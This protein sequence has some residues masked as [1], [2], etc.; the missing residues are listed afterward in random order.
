M[1]KK[2]QQM[3]V[4]MG[5]LCLILVCSSLA[6]AADEPSP[7][8]GLSSEPILTATVPWPVAKSSAKVAAF[9]S[10][11]T[12]VVR[13]KGV[14][15][16]T[17]PDAGIYCI[18]PSMKL[19]LTKVIPVVSVEWGWSSGSALLAFYFD[20]TQFGG[21]NCPEGYLEVLT[22]NFGTGTPVRNDTVAFTIHVH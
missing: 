6:M 7:N 14:A 18:K 9:I 15:D 13:A 3:C 17:H 8:G 5:A 12:G 22:Y 11:F 1:E 10:P 19:D 20:G 21:G 2:L 4:V 16:F